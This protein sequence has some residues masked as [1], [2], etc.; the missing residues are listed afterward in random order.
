[1]CA[2]GLEKMVESR[3]KRRPGGQWASYIPDIILTGI[4][5]S[6]VVGGS[7]LVYWTPYWSGLRGAG[8]GWSFV[9]D[10]GL[11]SLI[12]SITLAVIIPMAVIRLLVRRHR[13]GHIFLRLAFPVI[14]LAALLIPIKAPVLTVAPYLQGLEQRMLKKVNINAVQ[15]WLASEGLQYAGR[16]YRG[17]FPR[18]L[19]ACLTEFHPDAMLFSDATPEPGVTIEFRWYAPHGENFGLVVGSPFMTGPQEGSIRLPDSSLYEWRRPIKPGA[20]VFARG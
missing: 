8:T 6:L 2:D 5:V 11:K 4:V 18:E 1:M 15:Q 14:C 16:E 20:Y 17:S 19:P 10:M 9:L 13:L 12:A 7:H 3:M